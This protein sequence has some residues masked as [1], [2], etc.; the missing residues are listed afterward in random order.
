M[1]IEDVM[2]SDAPE[3]MEFMWHVIKT[4]VQVEEEEMQSILENVADNLRWSVEHPDV[5]AHLKCVIDTRIVGVV[6]VKHFWNLCSLFVDPA[7]QRMGI[8]RTL[9]SEAVRRCA[10]N[11]DHACLRVN[12]SPN[13]VRFYRT[14]R[15]AP[16]ESRQP[17]ASSVPMML[18]LATKPGTFFSHHTLDNND[19]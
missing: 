1:Q 9:L 10:D 14:M 8:G 13:A 16:D 2:A 3:L 15:F 11:G 4:S 19:E 12:S 7:F 18:T 5:C 17:R 6:L